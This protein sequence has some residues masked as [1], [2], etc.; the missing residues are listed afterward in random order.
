MTGVEI[1]GVGIH[2]FGR[3]GEKTQTEMGVSAVRDALGDAGLRGRCFQAAFCGTAY[4]GYGGYRGAYY[5]GAYGY[6]GG[7]YYGGTTVVTPG[8]TGWGAAAAGAAVGATTAA[9]AT[10]AAYAAASTNYYPPPY[11]RPYPY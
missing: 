1:A 3:H 2:P 9:A 6:H 7:T 5:G 11:Y 10:S 8:Y 4:G